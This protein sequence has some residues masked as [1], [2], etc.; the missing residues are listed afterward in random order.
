MGKQQPSSEAGSTFRANVA[1]ARRERARDEILAVAR[2]LVLEEGLPALTMNAVAKRLG[3]TKP[4]VYYYFDGRDA[5]MAAMALGALQDEADALVAAAEA[6][7]DALDAADRFVRTCVDHHKRNLD[8]FRV[9]HVMGQLVPARDR[10]SVRDKIP[11]I[12]RRMY[13]ALEARLAEGQRQGL[14][15]ADVEPRATAV[16]LHLAAL[17]FAAMYATTEA[18]GDPMKQSFDLLLDQLLRPLLRGLR[19]ASGPGR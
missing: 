18:A 8:A 17:G 6:G 19:G 4:A 13:D 9:V 11:P 12:T 3:V 14:I 10:E 1:E 5:L 15:A 7:S 16:S 2:A